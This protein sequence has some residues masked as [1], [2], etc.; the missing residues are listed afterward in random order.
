MDGGRG[1]QNTMGRG[2]QITQI[3]GSIYHGYGGQNTMGRRVKNT[4]C[5]GFDIPWVGGQNTMV[6][7]FTIQRGQFSIRGSIY[8]G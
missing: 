6:V 8:H 7:P 4:M 2:V 5:R 3:G 1:G